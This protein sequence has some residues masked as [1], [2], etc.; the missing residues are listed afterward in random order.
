MPLKTEFELNEKQKKCKHEFKRISSCLFNFKNGN[1]I[2]I[3]LCI[4]CNLKELVKTS[5]TI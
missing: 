4:K 1:S 3:G 5:I 2:C